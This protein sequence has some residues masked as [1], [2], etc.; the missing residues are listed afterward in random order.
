MADP[1]VIHPDT[2]RHQQRPAEA[3]TMRHYRK[4]RCIRL[5]SKRDKELKVYFSQW[6]NSFCIICICSPQ[7][8]EA[9]KTLRLCVSRLRKL[10]SDIV[11]GP[12]IEEHDVL[13]SGQS[14]VLCTKLLSPRK[15]HIFIVKKIFNT[16]LHHFRILSRISHSD[17]NMTSYFCNGASA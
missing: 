12:S 5:K 14:I 16:S 1:W 7:A 13:V 2:K 3:Q 15:S 10:T 8:S 11:Y 4:P 9:K 6:F 17:I